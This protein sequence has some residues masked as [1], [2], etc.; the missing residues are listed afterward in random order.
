MPVAAAVADV[1]VAVVVVV[2]EVLL[3][4]LLLPEANKARYDDEEAEGV[5]SSGT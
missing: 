1:V 2:V 5:P 4:A 3:V